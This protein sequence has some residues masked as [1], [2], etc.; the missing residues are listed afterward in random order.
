MKDKEV[1]I[2]L[3][4]DIRD[5]LQEWLTNRAWLRKPATSFVWHAPEP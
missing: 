4:F 1:N 3:R 5:L 2:V